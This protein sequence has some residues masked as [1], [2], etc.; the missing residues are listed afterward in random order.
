[1][2]YKTLTCEYCGE[3]FTGKRGQTHCDKSCA[4]RDRGEGRE[5]VV[6]E[7]C[8]EELHDLRYNQQSNRCTYCRVDLDDT[9]VHLDHMTPLSRGGEHVLDNLQYLCAD[10]NRRKGDKTH[11]EFLST[12]L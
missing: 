9:P 6:C 11:D 8:G 12:H 10:C 7:G 1:M 4:M 5:T 2:P 3:E